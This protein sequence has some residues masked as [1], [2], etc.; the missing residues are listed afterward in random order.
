MWTVDEKDPHTIRTDGNFI[1]V[2]RRSLTDPDDCIEW[3]RYYNAPGPHDDYDQLHICDID[4]MIAELTALKSFL[5][6]H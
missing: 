3:R 2:W 5:Q 6:E 4:D 1:E